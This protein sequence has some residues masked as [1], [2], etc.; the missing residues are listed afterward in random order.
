MKK[1]NMK[2]LVFGLLTCILIGPMPSNAQPKVAQ[3]EVVFIAHGAFPMHNIQAL[4]PHN[5][6]FGAEQFIF[7]GKVAETLLYTNLSAANYPLVYV[8]AEDHEWID[9]YTLE[10]DLKEGIE[11]HDGTPFNASAAKW[12][13]DRANHIVA[14]LSGGQAVV[15]E[16]PSDPFRPITGNRLDW[17]PAG[18]DILIINS[19]EVVSDYRIR[20]NLNVPVGVKVFDAIANPGMISPTTHGDQF[21]ET[22]PYTGSVIG[23]GPFTYDAGLDTLNK[24]CVLNANPRYWRGKPYIDKVIIQY[25]EDD[26]TAAGAMILGDIDFQEGVFVDRFDEY[27]ASTDVEIYEGPLDTLS[28][29]YFFNMNKVNVTIRKSISY[30]VNYTFRNEDHY[31]GKQAESGGIILNGYRFYNP[32]I[33]KPYQNLTIARQ[34]LVDAGIAP[35]EAMSWT[36]QQWIDVAESENPFA[37]VSITTI[38][39]AFEWTWVRDSCRYVG[40]K[41]PID[42]V[43]GAAWWPKVGTYETRRDEVDMARL[44]WG[45]YVPEP[46]LLLQELLYSDSVWNFAFINDSEIDEWIWDAYIETDTATRQSIYDDIADKVQNELY[47]YLYADQAKTFSALNVDWEGW[48]PNGGEGN[49]YTFREKTSDW[50]PLPL[51][52]TPVDP[53][54]STD[55]TSDDS[56][57]DGDKEVGIPGYS[58]YLIGIAGLVAILPI[59]KKLNR[60]N[61]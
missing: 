29:F 23:T 3:S 9:L 60:K 42:Q 14:N 7:A 59:L 32:D 15:F 26:N 61:K 19:T 44:I 56:S 8:L 10:I 27:V 5:S 43:D 12:N 16:V 49:F 55:D 58:I 37:T 52:S 40:I 30:A 54:A 46:H 39:D 1:I 50:V 24:E 51:D 47:P 38:P 4:D 18:E 57:D 35:S 53:D 28:D 21:N 36:D 11:F 22:I 6:A 25:F 13:F 48:N 17:V 33:P 20:F 45:W 2:L 31:Q 41:I 34:T